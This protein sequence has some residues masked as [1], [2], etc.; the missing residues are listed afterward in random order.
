M[1]NQLFLEAGAIYD[2]LHVEIAD[3]AKEVKFFQKL[4]FVKQGNS[5]MIKEI[6][7]EAVVRPTDGYDPTHWM[8]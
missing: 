8:D 4:G 5:S 2:T 1:L 3:K 7:N 6:K